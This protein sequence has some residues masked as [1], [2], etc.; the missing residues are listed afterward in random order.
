MVNSYRENPVFSRVLIIEYHPEYIATILCPKRAA[1]RLAASLCPDVLSVRL[2]RH[3]GVMSLPCEKKAKDYT[4][5]C[6]LL[7]AIL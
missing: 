1:V 4:D 7:F 3:K 2:W 5:V 6:I